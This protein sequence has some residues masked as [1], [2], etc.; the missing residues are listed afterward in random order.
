MSYLCFPN[1]LQWDFKNGYLCFFLPIPHNEITFGEVLLIGR[2]ITMEK[3]CCSPPLA[4]DYYLF[5][6]ALKSCQIPPLR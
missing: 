1:R 5:Y 3:S 4:P 6:T 2:I